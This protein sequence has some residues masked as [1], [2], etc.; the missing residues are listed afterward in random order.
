M[1]PGEIPRIIGGPYQPPMQQPQPQ[2]QPQAQA[3]LP[4]I[5]Q[6]LYGSDAGTP[7]FETS[8]GFRPE[9]FP[10]PG[11][12][13]EPEPFPSPRFDDFPVGTLPVEPTL[14]DLVDFNPI[15]NSYALAGFTVG[16]I[17]AMPEFEDFVKTATDD[18]LEISTLPD[19]EAQLRESARRGPEDRQGYVD[20]TDTGTKIG[21]KDGKLIFTGLSPT[22]IRQGTKLGDEVPGLPTAFG[23]AARLAGDIFGPAVTAI[24][25]F[26]P[27]D[28]FSRLTSPNVKRSQAGLQTLQ[29]RIAEEKEINRLREFAQK[30]S[31]ERRKKEEQRQLIKETEQ[32]ISDAQDDIREAYISGDKD[33]I[34]RAENNFKQQKANKTMQEK[35]FAGAVGSKSGPVKDSKGNPIGYGGKAKRGG[36]NG[37][38]GG[39][40]GGGGK[41][42]QSRCFVKGTML[43]MADGTTKEITTVKPGMETRGGTVEFV[44]QGLPVEI[45]DYKGV[46]VSGSHWVVEDNQLVAVEDSKHG[47]K[48][49]RF[50]PVYSMKTS[51]QRM[52]IKG[53]EFGDF[54]SGTDEDWEP[55]FEMV[56]QK[57]NK[58]LNGNI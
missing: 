47:I 5:I 2:E 39:N 8:P 28:F 6:Q 27:K 13:T 45:W 7:R 16:E 33:N 36:K 26:S 58:E 48:T 25:D 34:E 42:G 50:E 23:A 29:Q 41:Q 10:S 1:F 24:R 53:I 19:L 21:F 55:H 32:K 3:G 40:Q 56:R 12:R 38:G 15:A 4:L 51:K 22:N 11:F 9:P 46:K 57:L 35:G 14:S 54:E 18:P 31:E 43:E 52:W 30:A 37:G 44:L 20:P 49:D 17:L